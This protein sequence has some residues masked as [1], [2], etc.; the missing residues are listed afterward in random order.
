MLVGRV[1]APDRSEVHVLL[2]PAVVFGLSGEGAFLVAQ[3][4]ADTLR[5]D[6][7][8]GQLLRAAGLSVGALR[9]EEKEAAARRRQYGCDVTLLSHAQLACDFLRDNAALSP[10]DLVQTRPF[11]FCA[12]QRLP[13]LLALRE[14]DQ[15]RGFVSIAAARSGDCC[16]EGAAADCLSSVSY[17]SLLRLFPKV[18]GTADATH[19][20]AA[21]D[22]LHALLG[23]ATRASHPLAASTGGDGDLRWCLWLRRW[24]ECLSA[25]RSVVHTFRRA[26]L[27]S[28]DAG[29]LLALSLA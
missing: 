16:S 8:A 9:G 25:Q 23:L 17:L 18:C 22:C 26:V 19:S 15:Q 4:D 21:A 28:S 1:V 10:A 5:F 12:V 11:H 7:T 2:L 20:A 27:S 24:D 14:S 13:T 6:A 3:T 29:A